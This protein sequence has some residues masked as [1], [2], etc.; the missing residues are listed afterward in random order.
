MKRLPQSLISDAD[1]TLCES[2]ALIV[3][4]DHPELH[5]C[6]RMFAC[7]GAP[8]GENPAPTPPR[9]LAHCTSQRSSGRGLGIRL[10]IQTP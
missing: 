2:A 8:L 5:A 1:K 6:L 4:T 7:P 3:C 10:A 9:R